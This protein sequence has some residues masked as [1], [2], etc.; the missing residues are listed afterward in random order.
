MELLNILV[1]LAVI[2]CFSYALGLLVTRFMYMP[3]IGVY[4]LAG[5]ITNIHFDIL[6]NFFHNMHISVANYDIIGHIG[7]LL[8]M[9]T[10]G[11]EVDLVKL[12]ATSRFSVFVTI[13]QLI[14][15][16]IILNI[17]FF[18]YEWELTI[19]QCLAVCALSSTVSAIQGLNFCKSLSSNYGL[20]ALS[21]LLLQDVLFGPLQALTKM[22]HFSEIYS[23]LAK[24]CLTIGILFIAGYICSCHNMHK[25]FK[26]EH[27]ELY[28]IEPLA[29]CFLLSATFDYAGLSAECGAFISGMFLAWEYDG[30]LIMHNMQYIQQLFLIAFFASLGLY[31][32]PTFLLIHIVMI[33]IILFILFVIRTIVF[34]I[35][36]YF[37][38]R[39]LKNSIASASLL[40]PFSEFTFLLLDKSSLSPDILNIIYIILSFS[41]A[42]G[43][44]WHRALLKIYKNYL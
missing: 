1:Q 13:A 42:I 34:L 33:L 12:S 25:K 37:F 24:A 43:F 2:F 19:N 41:L 10:A 39:D 21:I 14:L 16:W 40:A 5:F 30:H 44:I 27:A 8:L 38:T 7:I 20:N 31:I 3:L 17:I 6:A 36:I 23:V 15:T 4:I 32:N 9:F 29:Y 35:P 11:L 18:F 22:T 26:Q 28:I